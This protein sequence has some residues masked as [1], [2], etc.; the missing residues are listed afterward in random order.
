M[1]RLLGPSA[2]APAPQ[3]ERFTASRHASHGPPSS[4]AQS[5][6]LNPSVNCLKPI[7]HA[8]VGVLPQELVAVLRL[9]P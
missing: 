7:L 8:P 6:P 9:H 4:T 3:R 2:A 5:G 1:W